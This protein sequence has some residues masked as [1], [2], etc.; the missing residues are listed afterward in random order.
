MASAAE[1]VPES[2]KSAT[3][4]DCNTNDISYEKS[5]INIMVDKNDLNAAY[6]R[7]DTAYDEP[8]SAYDG[9]TS[10]DNNLTATTGA[11]LE[12]ILTNHKHFQSNEEYLQPNDE[13]LQPNEEYLQP[14]DEYT[15]NKCFGIIRVFV[16]DTFSKCLISI[17]V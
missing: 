10:S 14:I 15:T 5:E 6:A 17:H 13:Y 7:L 16:P 4:E 11:C 9:L 3:Y 1:D 8:V 12:A 2:N